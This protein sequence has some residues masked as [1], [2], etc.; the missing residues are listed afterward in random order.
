MAIDP[1]Q[2]KRYEHGSRVPGWDSAVD[3]GSTGSND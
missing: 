3:W 1:S 2:V